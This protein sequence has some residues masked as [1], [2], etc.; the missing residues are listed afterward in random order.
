MEPQTQ[1]SEAPLTE[2]GLTFAELLEQTYARD[3]VIEGEIVTGDVVSV[4]KDF[5]L[6]DVGYKIPGWVSK[7]LVGGAMPEVVESAVKRALA[8]G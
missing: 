7:S 8:R 4:T 1:K 5:V 2:D 6:V 3:E